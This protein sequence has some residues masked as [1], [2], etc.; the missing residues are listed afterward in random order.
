MPQQISSTY[1]NQNQQPHPQ[2]VPL[3]NVDENVNRKFAEKPNNLKKVILDDTE[4]DD[5]Q[6][7]QI[8]DAPFSWANMLG[9]CLLE[10]FKKFN[11]K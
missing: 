6:N 1:Q 7:N 9:M 10:I 3:S 5:Y 4:E 8:Q 2:Y 11:N